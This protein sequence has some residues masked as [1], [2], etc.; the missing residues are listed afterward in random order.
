MVTYPLRPSKK[1]LVA[2]FMGSIFFVEVA[3]EVFQQPARR[4]LEEHRHFSPPTIE[5]KYLWNIS[6]TTLFSG[7]I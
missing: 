7:F 5:L 2:R 1:W 4:P 3:R 6:H